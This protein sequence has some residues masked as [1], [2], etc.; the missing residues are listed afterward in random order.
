MVAVDT[1]AAIITGTVPASNLR[2][3][4]EP[5]AEP[6]SLPPSRGALDFKLKLTG[7]PATSRHLALWLLL[8]NRG[9]VAFD[10]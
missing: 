4:A 6:T 3:F 7:C 10:S 5:F 9:L 1:K 8:K 2:K